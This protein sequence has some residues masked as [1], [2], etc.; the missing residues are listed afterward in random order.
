MKNYHNLKK[1]FINE[2]NILFISENDK[3]L[4]L[5]NKL[6]NELVNELNIKISIVDKLEINKLE[7]YSVVILADLIDINL[8]EL[9]KKTKKYIILLNVENS[10]DIE[11][12]MELN[13]NLIYANDEFTLK[14]KII[15][16]K[17]KEEQENNIMCIIK[18]NAQFYNPKSFELF[19]YYFKNNYKMVNKNVNNIKSFIDEKNRQNNVL[20]FIYDTYLNEFDFITMNYIQNYC[21]IKCKIFILTQDWWNTTHSSIKYFN[22]VTTNIFKANNYKVIVQVDNIE[23]LSNFNGVDYLKFKENIICYNY[24]GIYNSSII[25]FNNDPITKILISGNL[26]VKHYPERHLLS[27]LNNINICVYNYN[28]NDVQSNNNNFSKEL[29]KYM[30]CFTSSVYVKNKKYKKTMNTHTILLK[31]FEILASGSLLLV[32]DYEEPYLKKIGLINKK[33]YLTL[34]FDKNNNLNEQINNLLNENNLKNVNKIRYDGY[35]HAINNLTNSVRFKELNE[36]FIK[37]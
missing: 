9:V 5:E 3:A 32:P 6:I 2:K 23:L 37:L 36:M 29:N 17:K 10:N 19:N 35:I 26:I 8:D 30:C 24:W 34:N 14:N 27:N 18:E 25:E 1:I 16:I 7:E 15:V 31:I 28:S 21:E 22:D 13:D 20:I 12:F 33:H 11:L 4:E